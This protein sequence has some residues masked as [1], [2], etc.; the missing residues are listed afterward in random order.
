M[1][2]ASDAVQSLGIH[3]ITLTLCLSSN[4]VGNHLIFW[5]GGG[6]I[7]FSPANMQVLI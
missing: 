4:E 6:V 5:G 2:F 3:W 1:D 7:F